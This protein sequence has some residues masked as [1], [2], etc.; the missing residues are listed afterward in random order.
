MTF[1]YRAGTATASAG[2]PAGQAGN[3]TVVF[4]SPFRE[5]LAVLLPEGWLPQEACLLLYDGLGRRV[6]SQPLRAG[7]NEVAAEHLPAGVYF[8]VVEEHGA[9]VAQGRIVKQ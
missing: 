9:A 6:F 7:A 8:Y 4:P 1:D 5:R 3:P 2:G